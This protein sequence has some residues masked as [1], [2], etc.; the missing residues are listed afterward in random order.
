MSAVTEKE[1]QPELA[2]INVFSLSLK[3]FGTRKSRGLVKNTKV[4]AWEVSYYA[5]WWCKITCVR[6]REA[7]IL[8]S[9]WKIAPR[10]VNDQHESA[11]RKEA[12]RPQASDI[13]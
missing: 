1:M 8:V 10:T 3:D 7:I 6:N 12:A 11:T 9:H 2:L 13:R 4:E 5:E